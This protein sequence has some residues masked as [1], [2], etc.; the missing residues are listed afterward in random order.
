MLDAQRTFS[1]IQDVV[2]ASIDVMNKIAE[3]LDRRESLAE[4]LVARRKAGIELVAAQK[5]LRHNA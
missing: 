4:R 5:L 2:D 1:P 3:E